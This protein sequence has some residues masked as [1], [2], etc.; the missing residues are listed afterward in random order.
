MPLPAP[1]LRSLFHTREVIYRGFRR[2]DGLWDLEGTLCDQKAYAVTLYGQPP[3]PAGRPVHDLAVRLTL[4]DQFIVRAA[5]SS[6]DATPFTECLQARAPIERLVGARLGP[7]WRQAIERAMGGVEG[8]THLRE[9]LSNMATAAY[10]TIPSGLAHLQGRTDVP[11]PVSTDPPHHLGG[12][13]TW[14]VDGPVVQRH[15]P[16]FAGWAPLRRVRR[17]E[18]PKA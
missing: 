1:A 10:Q 7:G 12:C 13:I 8:C 6:M 14:D 11:H 3:R 9:L 4:D 16:Q 18:P 17:D 5:V 2:E 15:Y